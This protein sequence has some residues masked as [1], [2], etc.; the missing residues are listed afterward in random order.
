MEHLQEARESWAVGDVAA[1]A[2]SASAAL[3]L[4]VKADHTR[5]I[6]QA[7]LTLALVEEVRG[8]TEQAD[9]LCAAAARGMDIGGGEN[10]ALSCLVRQAAAAARRDEARAGTLLAQGLALVGPDLVGPVLA[11]CAISQL[12]LADPAAAA[13]FV[14]RA[15]ARDLADTYGLLGARAVIAEAQ[16]RHDDAE[17]L[18]TAAAGVAPSDSGRAAAQLPQVMVLRAR[19]DLDAAAALV[20]D[21]APHVTGKSAPAI[22]L[23]RAQLAWMRGDP[24]RAHAHCREGL[25]TLEPGNQGGLAAL[26]CLLQARLHL[27]A[28]AVPAARASVTRSWTH[29]SGSS[30]VF[31]AAATRVLR[32]RVLRAEGSYEAAAATLAR[33]VR[34]L[35]VAGRPLALADARQEQAHQAPDPG[36]AAAALAEAERLTAGVGHVFAL[37]DVRADQARLAVRMSDLGR[38]AERFDVAL[39]GYARTSATGRT[40]VVT[41]ERAA[42]LIPRSSG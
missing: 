4:F 10:A 36:T 20:D 16:G 31:R 40:A 19:G 33:A 12:A 18:M 39:V 6:A 11:R 21:L 7:R 5:G 35:E 22:P 2:R 25:A 8:A 30:D 37:A 28:G 41:A 24:L 9:E 27:E 29:T 23:F 26:L 38:A 32:A 17:A 14:A 1:C 42:L 15:G 34:V 13:W 3:L